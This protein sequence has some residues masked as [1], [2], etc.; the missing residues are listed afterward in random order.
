M[1]KVSIAG[2]VSGDERDPNELRAEGKVLSVWN[3]FGEAGRSGKTANQLYHPERK[4][5]TGGL[6]GDT[7]VKQTV[8]VRIYMVFWDASELRPPRGTT[9]SNGTPMRADSATIRE[10]A[11]LKDVRRGDDIAWCAVELGAA[12]RETDLRCQM[13]VIEEHATHRPLCYESGAASTVRTLSG[14]AKYGPA[15]IIT[16]DRVPP[17]LQRG[18]HEVRVF[19]IRGGLWCS[20]RLPERRGGQIASTVRVLSGAA[21]YGS[22]AILTR[23]SM[24]FGYSVQEGKIV[25]EN[26]RPSGVV[27]RISDSIE[28]RCGGK[29]REETRCGIEGRAGKCPLKID[30]GDFHWFVV[31]E[32][33]YKCLGK[34]R[35]G[36]KLESV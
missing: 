10:Y 24:K 20:I 18:E 32:K 1:T 7:Y 23:G 34:G 9:R 12:T 29:D 11:G 8:L 16:Q 3:G 4:L 15:A 22:A 28:E 6:R 19:N 2:R 35:A 13:Q 27:K 36:L 14:A 21:K 17:L 30:S 25:R 26:L 5:T 33:K 31:A